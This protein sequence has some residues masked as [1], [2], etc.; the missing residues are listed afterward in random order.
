MPMIK[1]L[2]EVME[3]V[4]GRILLEAA[5]CSKYHVVKSM[6]FHLW[7]SCLPSDIDIWSHDG[8]AQLG[9]EA[10]T[11]FTSEHEAI[12]EGD[13]ALDQFYHTYPSV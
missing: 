2:E 13:A 12:V 8:P 1:D 11:S 3:L 4:F 6:E 5:I 7:N 9:S 10:V